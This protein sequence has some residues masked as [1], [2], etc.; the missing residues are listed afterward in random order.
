ME[1]AVVLTPLTSRRRRGVIDDKR[2]GPVGVAQHPIKHAHMIGDIA[3]DRAIRC[4]S[5]QRGSFPTN[6]FRLPGRSP[7]FPTLKRRVHVAN[8]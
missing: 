3:D 4:G 6:P 8:S 7:S 2:R 5:G 1:P